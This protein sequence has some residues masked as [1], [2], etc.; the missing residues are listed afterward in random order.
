VKSAQKIV[1]LLLLLVAVGPAF[2]QSCAMCYNNAKAT[3]K[4][5]Q[6]TI[7]RAILVLLVPPVGAMTIGVSL[8]FRYGK[9]RDDENQL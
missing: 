2:A 6:R 9:K 5:A 8:A 3:P 4:D 1:L 7:N